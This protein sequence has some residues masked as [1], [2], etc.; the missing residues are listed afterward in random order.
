MT[1]SEAAATAQRRRASACSV[2]THIPPWHDKQLAMREAKGLFD[3]RTLLAAEGS[4]Y[5]V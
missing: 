2:L 4:V 3:G 5:Q 1:G